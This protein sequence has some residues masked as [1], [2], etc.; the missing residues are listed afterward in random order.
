MSGSEKHSYVYV[1]RA[2][3]ALKVGMTTSLDSRIR[4]LRTGSPHPVNEVALWR[5]PDASAIERRMHDA[6]APFRM[7]GE[8]F[9]CSDGLALHARK[10]LAFND[11]VKEREP[12]HSNVI[13]PRGEHD[14][15][16]FDW[17]ENNN[18]ETSGIDLRHVYWILSSSLLPLGVMGSWGTHN[19]GLTHHEHRSTMT[20]LRNYRDRWVDQYPQLSDYS[21]ADLTAILTAYM[22]PQ[23]HLE[24]GQAP[25]DYAIGWFEACRSRKA[26]T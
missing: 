19:G 6:L 7:Q 21:P 5:E 17:I 24:P 23:G 12:D 20:W 4:A 26:Q 1:V 11:A 3:D 14:E 18:L 15:Q 25:V 8:W 10:C 16:F 22:D 2:G 9:A 13:C